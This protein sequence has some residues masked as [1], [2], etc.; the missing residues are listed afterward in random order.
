[1]QVSIKCGKVGKVQTKN[2]RSGLL[3][4]DQLLNAVK[5]VQHL[6]QDKTGPL[7]K[8]IRQK[9]METYCVFRLKLQTN[10]DSVPS[11][12]VLLQGDESLGFAEMTLVPLAF[13]VDNVFCI[14]ECTEEVTSFQEGNGTVREDGCEF[15]PHD[16]IR[17]P[18]RSLHGNASGH[19]V[20][21]K[22]HFIFL[23]FEKGLNV[24]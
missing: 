10:L 21:L 14:Y 8:V 7:S 9:R 20:S 24:V 12:L 18:Q 3:P 2:R 22:S 15:L 19:G 11:F 16:L 23:G 4:L 17:L 13:E 5:K 6:L 1:M